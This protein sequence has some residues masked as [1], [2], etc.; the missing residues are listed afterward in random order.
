MK[1]KFRWPKAQQGKVRN[2]QTTGQIP[3]TY[4]I[5]TR[6]ITRPIKSGSNHTDEITN[7]C[8][9]VETSPRHGPIPRTIHPKPRTETRTIERAPMQKHHLELDRETAKQPRSSE[10]EDHVITNSS[11]F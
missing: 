7:Q 8:H 1:T 6:R 2:K 11:V 9:R 10:K 5:Q 4:N 3:W